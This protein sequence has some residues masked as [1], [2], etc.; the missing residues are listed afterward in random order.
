M[1]ASRSRLGQSKLNY[2]G[3]G[4]GTYLGELYDEEYL[5]CPPW[6]STELWTPRSPAARGQ[7]NEHKHCKAN[8]GDFFAW[9]DG[10]SLGRLQATW[11]CRATLPQGAGAAYHQLMARLADGYRPDAELPQVDGMAQRV[12][13][14]VADLAVAALLPYPGDWTDLAQAIQEALAG[15]GGALVSA[16]Y[17]D[18]ARPDGGRPVVLQLRGRWYRN[19][20]CGRD[21]YV[22]GNWADEHLAARLAKTAPDFVFEAWDGSGCA[23]WPVKAEHKPAEVHVTGGR[24]VLLIGSTGDPSTP[25]SCTS[26]RWPANSG[27]LACSPGTALGIPL[28]STAVAYRPGPNS[29]SGRSHSSERHGVQ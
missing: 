27:T 8:F 14:G 23:Y 28:T 17:S 26:R 21:L 2:L 20:V 22:G 10:N 25:Y 19:W 3:L 13:L 7:S 12:T 11:P 29:S 18:S 24:P 16:A 6:C 5:P 4:Y 15:Y 9:C 1:T